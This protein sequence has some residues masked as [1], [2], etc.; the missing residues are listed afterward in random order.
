MHF[1]SVDSFW[2]SL[3][4]Y[5]PFRYMRILE[6]EL[7]AFNYMFLFVETSGIDGTWVDQSS[8]LSAVSTILKTKREALWY[9]PFS[10][11]KSFYF[12]TRFLC[13][14]NPDLLIGS[15][16]ESQLLLACCFRLL[17]PHLE[18]FGKNTLSMHFGMFLF[19]IPSHSSCVC[20]SW[21][22]IKTF[23]KLL[24]HLIATSTPT[25]P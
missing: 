18:Y 22:H 4:F 25:M 5:Q 12:D 13:F 15:L 11:V 14:L 17:P 21:W 6:W 9:L 16:N 1:S 7:G 19:F 24:K 10:N 3:M 23:A 2:K 20:W 8:R